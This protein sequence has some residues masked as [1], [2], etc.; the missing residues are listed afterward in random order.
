[1]IVLSLEEFA[2]KRRKAQTDLEEILLP[3]VRQGLDRKKD[4]HGWA[5]VL[6]KVRDLYQITYADEGGEGTAPRLDVKTVN[7]ILTTL[8]RSVRDAHS[9]DLI[10]TWLATLI[11]SKATIAAAIDDPEELFLEWVTMEDN[12]VR[13]THEH[14]AGQQRPVGE[15][16][17]VGTVKMPYPGYP[18]G[19]VELWIN[20]RCT[21]RPVLA[22]EV[23]QQIA[24]SF[25]PLNMT[26]SEKMLND[27]KENAMT[28]QIDEGPGLVP[29]HGVLAPEGK[30]SGDKRMFAVDSMRVRPLPL[31]LTWQKT[32]G[33]GHE[34]SVTVARIDRVA[35]VDG[36]I[37]G[38]G[39]YLATAD[40][41][42]AVGL[43]AEFGR[44]GVSVDADD[45]AFELDEENKAVVFTS[46]R[47]CGA[48]M[49]GIPAFHEAWIALGPEPEGFMPSGSDI[50]QDGTSL[51]TDDVL[52]AALSWIDVYKDLAP[53]KTEDGPGWL[54]HP[55]DTD[56]LRDYWVSGPGA[57][58][59]NWGVPGD[60]N[61]CRLAVA[62]YV[63]PQYLSGYCANR[64]YDAL[65]FWPGRPV[66]GDTETFRPEGEMAEA[67]SLVAS[68]DQI[69]QPAEW[70]SMPEPDEVT[71]LTVTGEGQVFG[72]VAGWKECHGAFMDTCVLPPRSYTD[73]AYYATGHVLTTA[74][75]VRTGRITVGREGHAAARMSLTAAKDHY[76]KTGNAVADVAVAEGKHGIWVCGAIRPGATPEQVYALR[77]SDVSG[78]WRQPG[79]GKEKEMI[80]VLAVNKGGFN[81]P[82]VAA[83]VRDGQQISLVAAGMI[84]S[85]EARE[86][87]PTE[88]IANVL[89][90][91]V[92][93]A[94][95]KRQARKERMAELAAAIGGS[96]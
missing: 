46:A 86:V 17:K 16:F 23:G 1:M 69:V 42:E 96:N 92:A 13:L 7:L 29:W 66:S 91:Q 94:L 31:P 81:T 45:S 56:R 49:V 2:S 26:A 65:G 76:D 40:A 68:H 62:E 6:D 54:T 60:F 61:R 3:I 12:K 35:R 39:V 64:H 9:A 24:A 38:S 11:L 41:D 32:T 27:A 73:Y 70:F 59:I 77:A 51:V 89:A 87:D 78:D 93:A 52:V 72:H 88:R 28:E 53:G 19:P 82:R 47:A 83:A 18:A 75:P 22:S 25:S 50:Q 34:G 67:V 44:Y 90:E 85:D 55:I 79:W 14:T 43:V 33:Q 80:A 21:L 58:K 95:E 4:T 48:S 15:P 57:A 10:S 74:G 20:C 30:M 36:E 8:R 63:K 84:V 37:R 5:E 71:H